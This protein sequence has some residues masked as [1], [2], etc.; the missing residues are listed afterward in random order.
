MKIQH[1]LSAETAEEE[2]TLQQFGLAWYPFQRKIVGL[3]GVE[4]L[5]SGH[6]VCDDE[7]LEQIKAKLKEAK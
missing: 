6:Y 4:F 2:K 7:E 1:L 3:D 5:S